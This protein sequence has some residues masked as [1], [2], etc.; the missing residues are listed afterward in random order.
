M[1][2]SNQIRRSILRHLRTRPAYENMV[3][4]EIDGCNFSAADIAL[5]DA[6]KH[7]RV[8]RLIIIKHG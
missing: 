8:Y 2:Q 7:C 1:N 5:P 4:A 3:A 6:D